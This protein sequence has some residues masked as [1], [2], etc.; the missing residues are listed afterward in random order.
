MDV[1]CVTRHSLVLELYRNML[2]HTPSMASINVLRFVMGL[3]PRYTGVIG[4]LLE[5]V[6]QDFNG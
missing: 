1:S 5:I 2:K 6:M 3:S 4:P